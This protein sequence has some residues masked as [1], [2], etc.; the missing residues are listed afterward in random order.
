VSDPLITLKI[1][2]LEVGATDQEEVLTT[3]VMRRSQKF[4]PIL[5]AYCEKRGKQYLFDWNFIHWY[6]T[7][8]TEDPADLSG[9]ILEWKMT[10]NDFH[11]TEKEPHR[12]IKDNDII[13]LVQGKPERMY[14]I[15]AI[16]KNHRL[17]GDRNSHDMSTTLDRDVSNED[18][19]KYQ[20][21]E[22]APDVQG[23]QPTYQNLLQENERLPNDNQSLDRLQ[24]AYDGVRH[25]YEKQRTENQTLLREI[26]R[27]HNQT[28]PN[29]AGNF[30]EKLGAELFN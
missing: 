2:G 11:P 25:A 13:E 22:D 23:L 19:V 7:P 26:E 12:Y 29:E 15:K 28:I 8:N 4:G 24:L 27:L 1:K 3:I 17:N 21:I 30:S 10:P 16:K 18:Q 6:A 14:V 5:N 20:A 9:Q